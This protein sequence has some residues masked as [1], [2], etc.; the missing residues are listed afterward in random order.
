M[1]K[2]Y[3]PIQTKIGLL[4]AISQHGKLIRL[5]AP[6][7]INH[8]EKMLPG[9]DIP[10][11]QNVKAWMVAYNEGSALSLQDIPTNPEGTDF[12]RS[13]WNILMQIP[14]GK[15]ESY[16][17]I[18]R[19]LENRMGAGKMSAQAVGAAVGKN[20]IP[21]IIP[22]HRVLGAKGTLTGFRYGLHNKVILLTHEGIPYRK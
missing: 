13:V 10:V 3:L 22:C 12:Q 8:M 14:F 4:Y 6:E 16:G 1:M 20:P 17:S 19:E 15:A 11:L 5:A 2:Y 21:I 9:E 7:E 18:A